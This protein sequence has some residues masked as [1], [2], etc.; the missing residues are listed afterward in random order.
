MESGR[1]KNQVKKKI[2]NFISAAAMAILPALPLVPAQAQPVKHLSLQ[3]AVKMGLDNSKQL[4]IS[5]AK[6]EEAEARYQ[7]ALDAKL[8]SAKFT[9]MGSEA[10]IP[11][12]KFQFPGAQKPFYLPGNST[13]YLSTLGVNEAI[14]AGNRMKYART[15]AELLKKVASLDAANDKEE[16]IFNII[17]AYINLYKI[18]DSR[19]II[20]QNLQDVQG[21]L[22][23]TQKFEQNGLATK[24]DVLRFELEKSNVQLTAIELDN[25]RKIANYNMDILL[26][27]PDSTVVETDSVAPVKNNIPPLED[28]IG[29]ALGNRKDLATYDYRK[30]ISDL[31]IKNIQA[32]KLPELG[33]GVSAYYI[34]PNASF[35]PP[36]NAFLFPVTVGL[37]LSW[38]IGNLYTSRHKLDEANIQREEIST[39][40]GDM[41]DRV[42]MDVNQSYTGYLQSLEKIAVLETAV[43]QATENDRIMESK[44]QNQ[45]AT[46]TDRIDAQTLLYQSKVNLELARADARIAYFNLLRTTGTIQP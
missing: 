34:N 31:N 19:K 6:I 16:V 25:N 11:T 33:A 14:F 38:N 12:T 41:Q 9:A 8:P 29:Q 35:I 21:R 13:V 32:G 45:L 18:D 24:N 30:Q 2:G 23:E 1:K 40:Q 44:Y 28:F 3:E 17:N 10:F 27:L 20:A 42:K 15:S 37:N 4:K 5:N 26:G 22:G 46:T 7:Q 43:A 39:S 36:A